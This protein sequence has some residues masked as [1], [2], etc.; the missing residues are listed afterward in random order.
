MGRTLGHLGARIH[1]ASIGDSEPS[2]SHIDRPGISVC[3]HG[4]Q[5]AILPGNLR[6]LYTSCR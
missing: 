1:T 2:R 6:I 4:E 3:L 5:K